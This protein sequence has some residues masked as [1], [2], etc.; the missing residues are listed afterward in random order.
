MDYRYHH[1]IGKENHSPGNTSM[2]FHLHYKS[3]HHNKDMFRNRLDSHYMILCFHKSNSHTLKMVAEDNT[4]NQTR[5]SH[6]IHIHL[7]T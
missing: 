5:M 3:H 6:T 1:R 2:K 7:Y 4:H